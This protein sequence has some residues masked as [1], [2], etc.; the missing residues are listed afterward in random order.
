MTAKGQPP[1]CQS[2]QQS[3]SLVERILACYQEALG[4]ELPNQMVALQ[5]IARLLQEEAQ[6][7]PESLYSWVDRLAELAQRSHRFVQVLSEV[8]RIC[9]EAH[10]REALDIELIWKEVL[11]ELKWRLADLALQPRLSLEVNTLYLP[12]VVFHRILVELLLD[13]ARRSSQDALIL[14]LQARQHANGDVELVVQSSGPELTEKERSLLF[15]PFAVVL[16]DGAPDVGLFLA[17]QLV[18]LHG[19][20]L[21][22]QPRQGQGWYAV[23]LFSHQPTMATE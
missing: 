18:E 7:I 1:N 17:R 5:G 9:R 11:A 16:E 3:L 4:H 13:R 6:Q 21:E 14:E 8:G 22:I 23:L 12:R 15:S 19:G 20:Q 2:A 10:S